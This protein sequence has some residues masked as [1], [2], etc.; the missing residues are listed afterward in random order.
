[1]LVFRAHMFLL[2]LNISIFKNKGGRKFLF[3]C[4]CVYGR[5]LST[6][7]VM[8]KPMAIVAT[9]IATVGTKNMSENDCTEI[10]DAAGGVAGSTVNAVTA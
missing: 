5:F 1:M 8:A 7:I 2:F 9:M 6:R 3:L 4:L 10:L